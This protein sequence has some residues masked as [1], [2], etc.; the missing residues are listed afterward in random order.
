[1]I[2]DRCDKEVKKT[3]RGGRLELCHRCSHEMQLL[4][5]H[6]DEEGNPDPRVEGGTHFLQGLHSE[7]EIEAHLE[8]FRDVTG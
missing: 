5:I 6:R 4:H 1:M 3:F 7:E 8:M 2:C